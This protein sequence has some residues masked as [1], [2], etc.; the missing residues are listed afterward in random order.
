MTSGMQQVEIAITLGLYSASAFDRS[1]RLAPAED[2]ASSATASD[3]PGAGPRKW[4]L[5]VER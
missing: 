4:R 2:R 3:T 1:R 5:S